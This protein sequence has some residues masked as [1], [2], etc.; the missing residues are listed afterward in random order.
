M[1]SRRDQVQAQSYVLGRL[2][3]AL[4]AADPEALEHPHRRVAA[5][6]LAGLLVAAL[7]VAGFGVYGFLVPGGSKAWRQ[8]G[9]LI[10]ERETGAQYVFA[11]NQLLPVRNY[12]S[13]ALLFGK[14]PKLVSVSRKSL[15]GT[16]KG[17]PVGIPE[18]PDALPS[19]GGLGGADWTT[20]AI[21]QRDSAGTLALATVLA[22]GRDSGGQSVPDD[23]ALVVRAAGDDAR[24][25]YLVW[26]GTR[27]RLTEEWLPRVLGYQDRAVTVQPQ[28]IDLLPAGPDLRPIDVPGRGAAGPDI[29]GA[30]SRIGELFRTRLPGT[31]ERYY[32]LR[33]DGLSELTATEFGV[34][35]GDPR[36]EQAYG[37]GPVAP[38]ELSP[39]A[40]AQLPVSDE[41]GLPRSLPP[42]PPAVA[43]TGGERAWC[44]RWT[45]GE[46]V[47]VVADP[48][49]AG[50]P[51][52]TAG[53][54][55][56]SAAAAVLIQPNTGG[57]VRAGREGQA[58]GTTL[59]L[60]TDAGLR[61]PLTSPDVAK[62]LGYPTDDVVTVPPALLRLLPTGA[63]LDPAQ[64]AG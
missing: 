62:S 10:L 38:R 44:V 31:A 4:V 48:A 2:T 26:R 52:A 27:H 49:P 39:A 15:A 24:G 36:T 58:P 60:L 23:R 28:W 43:G 53:A 11:K 59:F 56:G 14:P 50:V 40:L 47:S 34:V 20:C 35:S 63:T 3:A 46:G 32:L 18:A 9:V 42:V 45:P 29:D 5:G 13:A 54:A 8:P 25:G 30:P 12:T 1:Q 22:V 21:S 6:I 41:P 16:P 51:L 17:Q 55:G 61:F 37:G 57:I 19:A 33:R 64:A 7:V